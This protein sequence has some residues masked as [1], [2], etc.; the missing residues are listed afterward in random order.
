MT[1]RIATPKDREGLAPLVGHSY[2]FA[3][4]GVPLWFDK[5]GHNH[6]RAYEEGGALCGGLIEIP[7]GQYFGGRRVPTLGIQGVAIG[8]PHRGKGVAARMMLEVLRG[9]RKRKIPLSTLYAATFTLYERVGY[10]RSGLRFRTSVD[11][12]RFAFPR[13]SMQV[14]ELT[15]P[16]E[17]CQKLYRALA[18]E[19]HGSLDRTPYMWRRIAEPR[20]ATSARTFQVWSDVSAGRKLEGYVVVDH[21]MSRVG[22][23]SVVL[24]DVCASTQ[25]AARALWSLLA[26]YQS[27]A[28]EVS[29]YGAAD[30]FMHAFLP[31]R[32][33]SIERSDTWMV[34][35]CDP[36]LALSLRGYPR[37]T[38][39]VTLLLSDAALPENSG[40][41]ELSLRAGKMTVRVTNS[42]R[43]VAITERGLAALYTGFRAPAELQRMGLLDGTEAE[44]ATLAMLFAGYPPAISDMF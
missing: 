35:I 17:A 10:E 19:K 11:L 34:R 9:A 18:P 29:F 42:K 38:A 4:E 23:S 32:H 1:L 31:E 28:T 21:I 2:G 3:T 12:R 8:V 25:R 44:L 24:H 7:M 5:A 14:R 41:Y 33:Y 30:S 36:A 27:V 22:Q 37:A 13:E 15:A 16:D 6:V 26:E 43:G 40:A 39:K 20:T